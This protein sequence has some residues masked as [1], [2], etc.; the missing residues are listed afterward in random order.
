MRVPRLGNGVPLGELRERDRDRR[1]VVYGGRGI[2]SDDADERVQRVRMRR[3]GV[4]DDVLARYRLRGW[5]LLRE[6]NMHGEEDERNNVYRD[7]AVYERRLPRRRLLRP[8]VQ[9]AVR[10]V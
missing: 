1:G 4:Q 3:G 8:G 9:W 6:R 7:G 5:L 10:G 2:L